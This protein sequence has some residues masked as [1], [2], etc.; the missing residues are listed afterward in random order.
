MKIAHLIITAAILTIS[1][2][3]LAAPVESVE[4]ARA[5]AAWQTVNA[6]FGEKVVIDQMAKL[7]VTPAQAQARVTRLSDAQIEQLAAQIDLLKSG[8]TIEHSDVNRLGP[9]RCI[10]R[11]CV[12]TFNHI[13][14]FLFCW[15]DV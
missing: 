1:V 12:A 13:M 4:S 2:S 9:L 3:V 8:G 5:T 11:Q 10:W 14:R 15:T 7:G 6:F